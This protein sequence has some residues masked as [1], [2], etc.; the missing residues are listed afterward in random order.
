M[1]KFNEDFNGCVSIGAKRG[2]R[3]IIVLKPINDDPYNV[4]IAYKQWLEDNNE[5]VP[6][7]LN[8]LLTQYDEHNLRSK[9]ELGLW[10][11]QQ[12]IIVRVPLGDPVAEH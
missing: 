11:E 6:T 8:L 4:G 9:I 5:Q 2:E 12:N 7:E 3:Q 10:L 1:I